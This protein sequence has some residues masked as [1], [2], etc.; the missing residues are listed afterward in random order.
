MLSKMKFDKL[1]TIISV[2]S[3]VMLSLSTPG[4]S[5]LMILSDCKDLKDGFIKNE[6]ILDLKKSLMTRNYIYD[7]KTYKKHKITDL[8]IKK[9]NSIERFIYEE[10][11]LILTDKIGYPQFFT[12]L[13]PPAILQRRGHH[14]H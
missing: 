5:E 12:L 14:L 1:K 13:R 10:E 3:F 4:Y 6:Y 2:S 9:K 7:S 8:S 11:N